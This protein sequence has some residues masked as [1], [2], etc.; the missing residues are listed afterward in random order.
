MG[1]SLLF[2]LLREQRHTLRKV[3]RPHRV[4]KVPHNQLCRPWLHRVPGVKQKVALG[5]AGDIGRSRLKGMA[6]HPRRQKE[7]DLRPVSRDFTC[8]IVL[9]EQCGIN[10]QLFLPAGEEAAGAG[11]QPVRASK[12]AARAPPRFASS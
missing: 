12:A 3:H 1:M 6:L 7:D 9:R 8:K 5:D 4:R 10:G 2:M 11:A